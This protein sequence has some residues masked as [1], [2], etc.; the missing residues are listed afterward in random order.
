MSMNF[1]H[2]TFVKKERESQI[3]RAMQLSVNRQSSGGKRMRSY[4]LRAISV[5]AG[6]GMWPVIPS[7]CLWR[8]ARGA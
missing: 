2:L 1:G 5:I 8:A 3:N 6:P 4:G 7:V